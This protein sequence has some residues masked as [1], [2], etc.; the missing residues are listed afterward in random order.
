[1]ATTTIVLSTILLP[2]L[3][4]FLFS[5]HKFFRRTNDNFTKDTLFLSCTS[6]FVGI[7]RL[8]LVPL[9]VTAL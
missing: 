4:Q 2:Q 7:N 3:L 5:L 1:P 9:R 6:A 8:H